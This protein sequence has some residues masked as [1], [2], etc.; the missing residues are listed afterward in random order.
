MS[1]GESLAVSVFCMLVVFGVLAGLFFLINV[2]SG[3]LKS[4]ERKMNK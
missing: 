2:S 4:F 3:I 1:I